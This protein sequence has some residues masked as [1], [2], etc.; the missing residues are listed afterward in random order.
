MTREPVE[1]LLTLTGS[2]DD[3]LAIG[4]APY[5]AQAPER[6]AVAVTAPGGSVT[7][8][9][10]IARLL[11]RNGRR[12][13]ALVGRQAR[14]SATVLCLAADTVSLDDA[15]CLSPID[16]FVGA[17]TVTDDGAQQLAAVDVR[18]IRSMAQDW[19]GIGEPEATEVFRLLGQQVFLPTL[20][21]LHRAETLVREVSIE[22][23]E[24]QRPD[25]TAEARG[26]IVERLMNGYPSHAY[27][28]L[29]ED[30]EELG[31]AALSMTVTER[32]V[33][34]DRAAFVE[35]ARQAMAA[36][37]PDVSIEHVVSDGSTT[38]FHVVAMPSERALS[39]TDGPVW[40]AVDAEGGVSVES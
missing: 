9:L 39:F 20:G 29:V 1:H 10:L 22:L 31:L 16:P 18:A 32:G 11:G 37:Y 15:A 14:S 5:A 3:T 25:L 26:R 2:I 19:F 7:A 28:L 17:A 8:A 21:A 13:R 30:C 34:A 6:F 12:W 33:L 4:L 24:R 35:Q 40:I 36:V 27:P 23:F 38:R